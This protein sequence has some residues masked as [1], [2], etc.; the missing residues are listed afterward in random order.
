MYEFVNIK[1]NLKKKKILFIKSGDFDLTDK[2]YID[3][4]DDFWREERKK[5]NKVKERKIRE[6]SKIEDA[7]ADNNFYLKDIA[8]L[9]NFFSNNNYTTA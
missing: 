7:A 6:T 3:E 9:Y 8:D 1:K 5:Y 2:N 4:L